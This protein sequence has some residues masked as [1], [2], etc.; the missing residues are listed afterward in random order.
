M[1]AKI[2]RKEATTRQGKKFNAYKLVDEEKGGKLIDCVIC[3]SVDPSMLGK[4]SACN[5]A[6]VIGDIEINDYSYEFPKAFVRSL[7]AVTKIR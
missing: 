5:K 2:I 4:L 3:K 1:E 7:E 6:G